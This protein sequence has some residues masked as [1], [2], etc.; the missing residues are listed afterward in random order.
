MNAYG[1]W[2]NFISKQT[3]TSHESE[4][5][6]LMFSFSKTPYGWICHLL[7]LDDVHILIDSFSKGD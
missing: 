4:T 2:V 6:A 5:V 1:G 3:I 7:S